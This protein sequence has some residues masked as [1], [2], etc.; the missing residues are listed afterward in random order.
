MEEVIFI[1]ENNIPDLCKTSLQKVKYNCINCGKETIK[2]FRA[3]LNAKH[4][5]CKACR[6]RFLSEQYEGGRKAFLAA[7]KEK[8]D[9]TKTNKYGSLENAYKS[10][11]AKMTATNLEK[12]GTKSSAAAEST[13]EKARQNNL[14]NFGVEFTFQ[15]SDVNAK[16]KKT[17][18]AKYGAEYTTQSSILNKKKKKTE[19]QK[20]G[21]EKALQK[22]IKEKRETTMME[23]YGVKHNFQMPEF[24]DNKKLSGAKWYKYKFDN[25]SFDSSYEVA[26][27]A[28][29]KS[30]GETVIREP[31]PGIRYEKDGKIHRYFPDFLVNGKLYE[32]KTDS[33]VKEGKLLDTYKQV[34]VEQYNICIVTETTGLEPAFIYMETTYGKEWKKLFK[35]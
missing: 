24:L 35:L 23:K 30:L 13:K 25:E 32:I 33:F 14:K 2:S 22:I 26:F 27:Y 29:H 16:R 28:Y 10:M 34:L 19:I 31:K 6:Q 3:F 21:S 9:I 18:E 11:S 4:F 8:S 20:Y 7:K 12:Y 15:R 1:S 5:L 17:M